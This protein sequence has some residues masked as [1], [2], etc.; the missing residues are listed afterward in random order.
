MMLPRGKTIIIIFYSERQKGE[1]YIHSK[2]SKVP[3]CFS[4]TY[5]CCSWC[6]EFDRPEVLQHDFL[7]K[8][9]SVSV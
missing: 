9:Q 3:T 7:L 5:C 4:M 1:L 2:R 6:K 8:K